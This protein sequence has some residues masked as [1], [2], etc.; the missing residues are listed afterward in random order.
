MLVPDKHQTVINH[1]CNCMS[2]SMSMVIVAS[3]D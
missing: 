2:M 1:D 3:H